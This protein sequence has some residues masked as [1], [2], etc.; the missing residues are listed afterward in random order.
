MSTKKQPEVS[1]DYIFG[2]LATDDLRLERMKQERSGLWH[3]Q[4]LH[5]VDPHPGQPITVTMG[6]R[7][8]HYSLLHH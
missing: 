7:R 1:A 4:R 8:P 3:D 5:P 6:V 2:S